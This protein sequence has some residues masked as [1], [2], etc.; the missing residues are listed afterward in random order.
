MIMIWKALATFEMGLKPSCIV[1][2]LVRWL[3]P[4]AMLEV[5]HFC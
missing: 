2:S 4:T 1:K 5:K 3:K